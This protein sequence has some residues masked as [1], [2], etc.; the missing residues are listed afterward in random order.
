MDIK[1]DFPI[2]QN[3]PGL[4]FLDSTSTTQKPSYVID[5]VKEYLE[6]HYANIHRGSYSLAENS[7]KLYIDSKKE[8]MQQIS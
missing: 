4:V 3:N 6:T 5:G 7:E 1:K 8:V 2:F